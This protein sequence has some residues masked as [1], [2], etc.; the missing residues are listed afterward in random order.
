MSWLQ[1]L[2]MVN[3]M[4]ADSNFVPCATEQHKGGGPCCFPKKQPWPCIRGDQDIA[5][6]GRQAEICCSMEHQVGRG[7]VP[8]QKNGLVPV[9]RGTEIPADQNLV[10]IGTEQHAGRGPCRIPKKAL[11]WYLGG[12]KK[13]ALAKRAGRPK[14]GAPLHGAA[15]WWGPL[16]G[17]PKKTPS[18][19]SRG[20]PRYCASSTQ[21]GN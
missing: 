21:S 5:P 17:P 12:V 7:P 14:F 1:L 18:R 6:P 8:S 16:S 3:H 11:A 15:L 9:F 4:Q 10:A 2:D 13:P 20:G 19:Y